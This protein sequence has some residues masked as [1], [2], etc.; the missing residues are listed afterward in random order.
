M[1]QE[2]LSCGLAAN[3]TRVVGRFCE[4]YYNITEL[5]GPRE[6]EI[7]IKM[8]SLALAVAQ[9][10]LLIVVIFFYFF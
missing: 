6:N 8:G 7:F 4:F 10:V 2:Q 3:S 5:K 1:R 9:M